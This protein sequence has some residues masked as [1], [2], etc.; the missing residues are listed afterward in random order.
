MYDFWR[1]TLDNLSPPLSISESAAYIL[2]IGQDTI[3]VLRPDGSKR[4]FVIV[5]LRAVS[6]SFTSAMVAGRVLLY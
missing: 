2:D 5:L 1:I 4:D 3:F 6:Q